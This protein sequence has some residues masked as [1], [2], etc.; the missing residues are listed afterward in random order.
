MILLYWFLLG[1]YG[2][3]SP[4]DTASRPPSEYHT[5]LWG[6]YFG[7]KTMRGDKIFCPDAW[8]RECSWTNVGVKNTYT[9]MVFKRA[10]GMTIACGNARHKLERLH[11]VT[12]TVDESA[13]TCKRS[14]STHRWR[15]NQNGQASCGS[16]SM[17]LK[18]T[19]RILRLNSFKRGMASACIT[20]GKIHPD[21]HAPHNRSP[22]KKDISMSDRICNSQI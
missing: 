20:C 16:W 6:A 2:S 5:V 11:Y 7:H 22:S 13:H 15:A 4:R 18:G 1:F 8:A 10:I 21:S 19:I 3:F 14:H 17:S 12:S 9:N